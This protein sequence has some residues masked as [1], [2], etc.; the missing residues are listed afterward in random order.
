M[1]RVLRQNLPASP[2]VFRG[3]FSAD[4]LPQKRDI[5]PWCIAVNTDPVSKSGQHWVAMYFDSNGKGHYYDPFGQPPYHEEWARY[6]ARCSKHG[7]YT[8]CPVKCQTIGSIMC[9]PYCIRY[10]LKRHSSSVNVPDY[11]LMHHMNDKACNKIEQ[12]KK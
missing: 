12:N 6:L 5:Y 1:D 3:V 11:E 7:D 2:S 9:G 4:N 10:L 8:V